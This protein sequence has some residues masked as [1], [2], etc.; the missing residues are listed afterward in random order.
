MVERS[1]VR[2]D[3]VV[4]ETGSTPRRMRNVTRAEIVEHGSVIPAVYVAA[5][6]SVGQ[7]VGEPV[8]SC[9]YEPEQFVITQLEAA[10]DTHGWHWDDYSFAL[11]WIAECPPEVDGGFVECVPDTVW[12]KRCPRVR[13]ILRYRRV[14]RLAVGAGEVYL[15]RTNTTLH[16]VH[17]I[18]RGRR[19]IV[20]M[21]FAAVGELCAEVSHET[22]DALW[23]T[24][25][26]E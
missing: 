13:Q 20:N 12:D 18:H 2:R 10:G 6:L 17:P 5:A 14:H 15:M 4:A 9:P 23:A 24:S 21:A 7:I 22:M 1:G 8:F 19:T 3:L 16:R 25:G 26:I 11:V